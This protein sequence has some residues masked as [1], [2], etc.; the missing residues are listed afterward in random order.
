M[1]RYLFTSLR[2]AFITMLLVGIIYPLVM[3]GLAQLLFP[4]QA[5]GSLIYTGTTL[6]GSVLIGQAFIG[7]T[8]FHAR[9]SAA[10]HGYDALASGGSNL[11]P[12]S[13]E[14]ATRVKGDV[15]RLRHDNPDLMHIPVDMV[16]TSGSGL[17]PDITP[18]SA[19]MQAPRV[20]RARGFTEE[21]VRQLVA[22]HITGR[23][24]GVLGEPR[25]NVLQLNQALDAMT[26]ISTP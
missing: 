20:A 25:V 21:A 5:R 23:Q 2:I 19:Y 11:G 10:G 22:R 17:D 6:S 26:R 14:L 1:V 18:A 12:T 13:A 15:Q 3:T 24:F 9:P 8:Y 7:A 16:T 4:R